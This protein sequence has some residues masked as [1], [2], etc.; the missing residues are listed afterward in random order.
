M[1]TRIGNFIIEVTIENIFNQKVKLY[2]FILNLPIL[3]NFILIKECNK[4]RIYFVLWKYIKV[5][6]INVITN[7]VICLLRVRNTHTSWI[8]DLFRKFNDRRNR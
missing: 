7:L 3:N 1:F 5:I 2:F 4:Q 8:Y 6:N